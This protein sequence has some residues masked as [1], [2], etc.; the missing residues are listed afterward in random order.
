V[1]I[2]NK[3]GLEVDDKTSKLDVNRLA[4]QAIKTKQEIFKQGSEDEKEFTIIIKGVDSDE[5]DN[6]ETEQETES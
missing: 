4:L 3:A 5:T 6:L 2:A 1:Q